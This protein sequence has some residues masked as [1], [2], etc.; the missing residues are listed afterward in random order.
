MAQRH[1]FESEMIENVAR[2][3]DNQITTGI[4]DS[5][6]EWKSLRSRQIHAL[7]QYVVKENQRLQAEINSLRKEVGRRAYRP[8]DLGA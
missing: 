4:W 8:G 5:A 7:I 3:L 1:G 2:G 6:H